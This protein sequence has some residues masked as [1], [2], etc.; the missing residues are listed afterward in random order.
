M[1]TLEDLRTYLVSVPTGVVKSSDEIARRL[2]LCWHELA[3]GGYGGMEGSKIYSPL[4]P[5]NRMESVTWN[6]PL[7]RFDIE[8]HGATV[9]GSI[10][11]DVQSWVI[12][13][14]KGT[15]ILEGVRKRQLGS[16]AKSL[17]TAAIACE[18][19]KLIRSGNRDNR[20]KWKSETCV[21]V[22]VGVVIPATNKQTTA[23]RRKRFWAALE[24]ELK[25]HG[26]TRTGRDSVTKDNN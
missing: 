6:P 14:E 2:S 10:F 23:G 8:R 11:A 20:L 9:A 5:Y 4:F 24:K 7:L 18:I 16:R 15:A 22:L 1:S 13:L 19:T 21:R 25:Q 17:D 26:W 3:A 12:N